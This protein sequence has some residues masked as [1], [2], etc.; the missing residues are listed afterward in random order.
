MPGIDKLHE[1]MDNDVAFVLLSFDDDFE[2]DS[3]TINQ[4]TPSSSRIGWDI[5]DRATEEFHQEQGNVYSQKIIE[6][7]MTFEERFQAAK[8]NLC[9]S[10]ENSKKSG[11]NIGHLMFNKVERRHSMGHID[12]LK[13]RKRLLDSFTAYE[14]RPISRRISI[15][16]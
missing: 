2:K 14:P 3:H 4:S 7:S 8:I 16:F 10:M 1:Q 13:S 15:G 11:A 12:V 9:K 6:N 5:G